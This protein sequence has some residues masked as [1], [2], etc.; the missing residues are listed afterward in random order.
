MAGNGLT[1][2]ET[3][4]EDRKSDFLEDLRAQF[5]LEAL[6]ASE[7]RFDYEN[8]PEGRIWIRAFLQSSSLFG[9]TDKDAFSEDVRRIKQAALTLREDFEDALKG[10][11]DPAL[12]SRLKRRRLNILKAR[13][14]GTLMLYTSRHGE[15]MPL[16]EVPRWMPHSRKV[17]I[18]FKVEDLLKRGSCKAVVNLTHD[19]SHSAK[20]VGLER[21]STVTLVRDHQARGFEAGSILCESLETG[22]LLEASVHLAYSWTDGSLGKLT[23][24][25]VPRY[26]EK[27]GVKQF[28]HQLPLPDLDQSVDFEVSEWERSLES[29][30]SDGRDFNPLEAA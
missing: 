10:S 17:K 19:Q 14:S 25:E 1:V 22:V 7:L 16:D 26:L 21:S 12:D 9:W 15:A 11:R 27:Q 6:Q 24:H 20:W 4:W 18:E 28:H 5:P 30:N 13:Q 2:S 29:A 8:S 3:D 23:L